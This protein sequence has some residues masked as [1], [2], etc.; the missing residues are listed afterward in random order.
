LHDWSSHFSDAIRLLALQ[1]NNIS[2]SYWDINN[3]ITPNYN[4]DPFDSWYKYD[5]NMR[6]ILPNMSDFI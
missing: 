6:L 1:I 2:L 4:L 5:P 3:A